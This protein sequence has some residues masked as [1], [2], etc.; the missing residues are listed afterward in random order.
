MPTNLEKFGLGDFVCQKLNLPIKKRTSN[1]WEKYLD[2]LAH[3][4]GEVKIGLIAKYMS[5]EDTYKSVNEAIQAAAI[6]NKKMAKIVWIDAEK[7]EKHGTKVLDELDGIIIPGGFGNRGT[8]GKI[9]A[10]KYAREKN[11][12]YLGLCLGMQVAVIEFA[13][14]V[15]NYK[16]ANSAEFDRDSKHDVIH[17]MPEQRTCL[18][19][20]NFGATMRLGAFPC[21]LAKGSKSYTLYGQ[22]KI[23]ERHRH[24]YEFNNDYRKDFT[25]A[26]LMIVGTSPNNHL[27]EVIE[28]PLHPFFVGVQFHPEFKSRPD[29]PH[30]LFDGFI[31]ACLN[32]S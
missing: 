18:D 30:P 25:K 20:E 10:C 4:E 22:D 8:E 19:E 1:G 21:L 26:G 23:S 3:A 12:P 24:R 15:L 11:I 29:R 17:I 28:L 31:K 2:N 9:L 16:D 13:R 5:N 14:N 7:V 32:Q 27:V 6:H